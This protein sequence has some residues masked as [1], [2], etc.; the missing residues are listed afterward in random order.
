MS[1]RSW[2]PLFGNMVVREENLRVEKQEPVS[3][4]YSVL[5]TSLQNRLPVIPSIRRT[6]T[7]PIRGSMIHMPFS[8]GS[9]TPLSEADTEVMSVEDSDDPA[10]MESIDYSS[11]GYSSARNYIS[12]LGTRPATPDHQ[13]QSGVDWRYAKQGSTTYDSRQ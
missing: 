1:S 9:S 11:T 4:M 12:T 8:S 3:V 6:V 2:M 10:L 5:P 13:N 7:M